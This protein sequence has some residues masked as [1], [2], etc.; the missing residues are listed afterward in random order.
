LAKARE[1]KLELT[2]EQSVL[3]ELKRLEHEGY[4]FEAAEASLEL[5]IHKL[6]GS[7]QTYFELLDRVMTNSGALMP[8]SEATARSKFDASRVVCESVIQGWLAASN[9]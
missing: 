4:E 2:N 6:R 5:L 7:H 9:S 3:D 8:M 1:L